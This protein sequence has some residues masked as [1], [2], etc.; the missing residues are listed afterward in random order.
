MPTVFFTPRALPRVRSFAVPGR[1]GCAGGEGRVR[2]DLHQ[3]LD[4]HAD[5]AAEILDLELAVDDLAEA[6]DLVIGQV[7]HAR[8]RRHIARRR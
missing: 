2:A 8:V 6:V 1:G 4:V 5:L 7:A 3:A